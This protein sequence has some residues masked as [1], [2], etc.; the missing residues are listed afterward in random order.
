MD[1]PCH[2]E[3]ALEAFK[4]LQ[5]SHLGVDGALPSSGYCTLPYTIADSS[6]RLFLESQ[7]PKSE[8]VDGLSTYRDAISLYLKLLVS[9]SA[10]EGAPLLSIRAPAYLAG[11]ICEEMRN[12]II[13]NM[14]IDEKALK[15]Q[16]TKQYMP[17]CVGLLRHVI[18]KQEDRPEA[19][20]KTLVLLRHIVAGTSSLK[21]TSP[22][23]DLKHS[24]QVEALLASFTEKMVE[25]GE[26]DKGVDASVES[27]PARH[28][29]PP[30][31]VVGK[32]NEK[33][34]KL[35]QYSFSDWVNVVAVS[36]LLYIKSRAPSGASNTRPDQFGKILSLWRTTAA[37]GRCNPRW[38]D[39]AM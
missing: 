13:P 17:I 10:C 35:G 9:M 4:Q 30:A 20:A 24:M 6:F 27:P 12:E 33:M 16:T 1:A 22:F 25:G 14:A 36:E 21:G 38:K 32:G 31:S 2:W 18:Y 19:A 11:V 28:L 8:S 29:R 37:F 34:K 26:N 3:H 15:T 39:A 23:D 5:P 7:P